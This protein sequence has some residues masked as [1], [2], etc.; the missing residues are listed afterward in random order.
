[1]LQQTCFWWADVPSPRSYQNKPLPEKTD[2]VVIGGG[3]TGTSA[4][5]RLAKGGAKVTLLEAETIGWGASSRNGGQALSCLHHTLSKLIEQHGLER[6]REMFRA[7][8]RAADTVARIVAEEGIDCDYARNGNIEAASKPGHFDRL[9]VEQGTLARVADYEVRLVP[10]E[11][12]ATELGT[13]SYHGLLVNERSAGLQPAKF[14]RGLALAA[15]RA[16]ADVHERTRVTEIEKQVAN[17]GSRFTVRTERGSVSTKE[18]FLAANA[19]VGSIVPQFRRRVF[20][21]ES[22]VIATEQLPDELAHKLI[23]NKRVVYDTKNMVAY[24]TLSR[25]N[26]MVWGGEGTATGLSAKQNVAILRRG[27][28]RVFPELRDA[29]IDYYWGGTLGLT[30]D[31]TAHAGQMDGMWFSM[32]YVGHGVTLA[33]YLGEQMANAILGLESFNPFDGLNIPRVPFY[34][35]RAWFVNFGKVWF[36]LLDMFG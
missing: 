27:M 19:W 10:P 5:L 30:M 7:S 25:E 34:E 36:R 6:A 29:A 4:A 35:G 20:P 32:C 15:E 16:G 21:A 22:F 33:T 28:L 8:V 26:R 13:D 9:K 23:P 12:V 1:M 18:V 11:E 2:V 3:L 31:Q 24:Y 14:V 17:D